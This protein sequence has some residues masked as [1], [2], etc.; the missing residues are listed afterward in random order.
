[1]SHILLGND[2]VGLSFPGCSRMNDT[3]PYNGLF[4]PISTARK[5]NLENGSNKQSSSILVHNKESGIYNLVAL[6][7]PSSQEK[8]ADDKSI[9]ISIHG[10]RN[11]AER[12]GYGVFFAEDS[13]SWWSRSMKA[14]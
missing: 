8:I 3:L 7:S 1:M 4:D 2:S 6:N 9:V 11:R 14:G 13:V 5:R 12:V 10:A